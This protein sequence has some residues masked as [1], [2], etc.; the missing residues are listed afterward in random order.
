MDIEFKFNGGMI[1]PQIYVEF[2]VIHTSGVSGLDIFTALTVSLLIMC[3]ISAMLSVN[4]LWHNSKVYRRTKSLYLNYS[5]M[6]LPSDVYPNW[7]S[8]PFAVKASFFSA[9]SVFNIIASIAVLGGCILGLSEELGAHTSSEYYIVFGLGIMLSSANM[10]RY[11][12]YNKKFFLH[13]ETI[14]NAAAHIIRFL[15]SVSPVYWGYAIFGVLNFGP[16]SWKFANLDAASVTLFALLTGDDIHDTFKD[17]VD[18]SYPFPWVSRVYIYSF[19]IIFITTVL[20]V[21][22]FIIEDAYVLAKISLGIYGDDTSAHQRKELSSIESLRAIFNNL[23]VWK[24]RYETRSPGRT[25]ESTPLR[26]LDQNEKL[27]F[28]SD[29][30]VDEELQRISPAIA[31]IISRNQEEFLNESEALMRE[32]RERFQTNLKRDI[33]QALRK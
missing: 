21:F 28:P 27:E 4:D 18:A 5:V 11:F 10:I 16:Y 20:N 31:A 19:V 9:W 13:V 3:V 6:A 17:I 7:K 8:I 12:E 29:L 15:V 22:I 24:Q 26:P 23:E 2:R 30:N 33:L 25:P 1:D 14:R 32:C